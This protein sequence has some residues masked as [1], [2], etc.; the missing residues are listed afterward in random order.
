MIFKSMCRYSFGMLLMVLSPVTGHGEFLG[1]GLSQS[2]EQALGA[3]VGVLRQNEE[4]DQMGTQ[5]HFAVRGSGFHYRDGYVVTARH[6]VEQLEG[7]NTVIP[8][9]ITILTGKLEEFRAR[10]IGV[11]AFLDLTVYRISHQAFQP[12][13]PNVSFAEEKV[14]TGDEVFTVGYPLGWGPAIGFGRLGNLNTF[15]PTVQTRLMQVDLSACS[16]NSGGGLFNAKGEVVGMVH[17]IIQTETHQDERR[18]S[19]LAF[20]VPGQ[21]VRRIVNAVIDGLHPGFPRIGINMTAVRVGARWRVAVDA[22]SGPAKSA[23]ILKGDIL[24]S[25]DDVEIISAAHLKNYLIEHKA[26][27][28]QVILRVLRGT[29]E[30]FISVTLGSA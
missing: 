27:G 9:E 25:I 4:K 24:I 16:G 17:A 10:L 29:E 26:P 30:K 14:A 28:Q 7:S 23:G 2:V 12:S 3:T 1:S 20:A 8:D 11:N 19:R 18:C 13:L 22:V 15:L 5:A 6:A 21:L